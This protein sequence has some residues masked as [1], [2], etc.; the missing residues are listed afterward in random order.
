MTIGVNSVYQNRPFV[1]SQ[2]FGSGTGWGEDEL[3]HLMRDALHINDRPTSTAASSS[4]I[5]APTPLPIT[6]R[7]HSFPIRHDD[8]TTLQPG[9]ADFFTQGRQDARSPLPY[10]FHQEG[11]ISPASPRLIGYGSRSPQ[12]TPFNRV[13]TTRAQT[14]QPGQQLILRERSPELPPLPLISPVSTPSLSPFTSRSHTPDEMQAAVLPSNPHRSTIAA[15]LRP[16]QSSNETIAAA[17]NILNQTL[18]QPLATGIQQVFRGVQSA[19]DTLLRDGRPSSSTRMT[20]SAPEGYIHQDRAIRRRIRTAQ[21][22]LDRPSRS[23]T[24]LLEKRSALQREYLHQDALRKE[25]RDNMKLVP[26]EAVQGTEN[27]VNKIRTAKLPGKLRRQQD[28]KMSKM[29]RKIH[30]RTGQRVRLQRPVQHLIEQRNT[31]ER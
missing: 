28:L 27:L 5:Y 19:R 20:D 9:N 21:E 11:T 26:Y 15:K 6:A 31:I 12:P 8:G 23:E 13:S 4:H 16:Y 25:F 18:P 2:R 24:R 10:E 30:Q 22:A 1:K 14:F 3:G 29:E 17:S 7:S